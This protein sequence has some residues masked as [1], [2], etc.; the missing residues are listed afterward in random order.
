MLIKGDTNNIVGEVQFSLKT[1]NEFK[2][3]AHNLYNIQRE[4]E[5]ISGAVK[6]VLPTLLDL[7]KQRNIAVLS[8]DVKGLCNVMV[9]GNKSDNEILAI[10][11]EKNQSV[12]QQI[13]ICGSLKIFKFVQSLMTDD[14]LVNR[15]FLSNW[16]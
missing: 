5:F 13:C 11:P 6:N 2:N 7:E 9:F 15:L 1:M 4:E 16:G 12:L 14:E 10:D 8:N 3:K